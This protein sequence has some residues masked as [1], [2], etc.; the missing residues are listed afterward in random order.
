MKPTRA[1]RIDRQG[2]WR[3]TPIAILAWLTLSAGG[4]VVGHAADPESEPEA[5]RAATLEAE[6]EARIEE[7]AQRMEQRA[8]RAEER[9]KEAERR[10]E[11]R[12]RSGG[13]ARV[14]MGGAI[15]VREGETTG[16]VVAIGG[17]V[18]VDGEVIGDAVAIGGAAQIRGRVTGDV[19]SVGRGVQ[20]GP[21]SLVLGEVVSVGGRIQREEGARVVGE[22]TEVSFA[23]GFFGPL[24]SRSLDWEWRWDRRGYFRGSLTRVLGNVARFLVLALLGALVVVIAPGAIE[25]TVARIQRQPVGAGVLGLTLLCLYLPLALM[26]TAVLAISVIGIPLILLV[27]FSMPVFIAMVF[28]GYVA[29][30]TSVG[31]W[32]EHRFGWS[33]GGPVLAFLVGL[34]FLRS[35]SLISDLINVADGPHNPLIFLVMLFAGVGLLLLVVASSVGLGGVVLGW[36]SSAPSGPPVAPTGLGHGIPPSSAAS[37]APASVA[38]QE[39]SALRHQAGPGLEHPPPATPTTPAD[40]NQEAPSQPEGEER[41]ESDR[42]DG[43]REESSPPEEELWPEEEKE[44]DEHWPRSDPGEEPPRS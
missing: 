1:A 37:T 22:V 30:A 10:A 3:R 34:L 42:R 5:D 43:V 28:F 6:L 31:R 20:L 33:L 40:R 9:A 23:G 13:G 12:H 8:L 26:V 39:G 27:L 17:S 18:T 24:L 14:T 21:E 2:R 36:S 29:A 19:V 7:M 38:S 35:W 41:L 4:V 16:D 15:H 11:R 25:R 44:D 32:S